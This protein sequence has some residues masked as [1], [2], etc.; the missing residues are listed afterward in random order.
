MSPRQILMNPGPVLVDDRVRRALSGPDMCH[1]ESEF[2]EMMARV[3]RKVTQVC[4]GDDRYTTVIFTGSG[5]AAL[6]A[7]LSS[8]VLPDGKMLI[9]DNGH[10]G[11]R[12][13]KIAFLHGIPHEVIRNG[14]SIPFD[15]DRVGRAISD[16]PAITHIA[17]VHHETS[18]G[19]LNPLHEI[20]CLSAKYGKS[21]MVDAISS[22]GGES[23][24]V[25][26]DHIDWCVGTANKCLEGMPG[27]SFVCAPRAKLDAL[28]DI[29]AR[30]L[31]LN[32]YNQYVA[33]ERAHAP[34]FTPAVQ[35]FYA[36]DVAL[37]LM[38][39]E[40]VQARH[41]RY[42][43]LAAQLRKG[44][45]DLNFRFLLPPEHRSSTLTA[46]YLP[47]GMGYAGLHDKLKAHGFVIYAAQENLKQKVFRLANM[48]QITPGDIALFL[49]VLRQVITDL[50]SAGKG[51]HG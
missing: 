17:M 38:L 5:T 11:E 20:G 19:M 40:G 26:A 47:E 24:D 36:F 25:Q 6:E 30:T 2:S 18:T 33:T 29:P 4:G 50:S 35:T 39:A 16:N 45:A 51:R 22:L 42:A 13:S 37:D 14:W 49:K 12:L 32:L 28:A 21:L 8:S 10:Y 41:A 7:T 34:Q 46:I 48:G 1:R 27:L 44:L 43:E 3:G 9:L 31:Y 15:L 23:L